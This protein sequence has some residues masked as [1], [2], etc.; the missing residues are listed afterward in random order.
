MHRAGDALHA[1]TTTWI[2]RVSCVTNG[3]A[4]NWVAGW[5]WG[6]LTGG[7]IPIDARALFPRE[8]EELLGLLRSLEEGDWGRP[9]VCPGWDVHDVTAHVLNDYVRRISGG[10]DGYGGAGFEVGET[11]PV[12]LGRV[13]GEFVRGLRQCSPRLMIELLEH[14]GPELDRVWAATDLAGAA[15][16]DVSWAGSGTSPAW[17]DLARE[18]TEFW[19]HQQQ[20][21]DA[22]SRPGADDVSMVRPVLVTLLHA[23]PVALGD[24]ARPAGTAVRFDVTGPAGGR[25]A[26]VSD[27]AKWELVGADVEEPAATVR[28]DQDTLWRLASRGISVESARQRADSIG[29]PELIEAATML[30]AVVA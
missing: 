28:M 25:W 15:Y 29:D 22:V 26:A 11:L 30:L 3:R 7:V 5:G 13:N 4:G 23:L 10:R 16:L 20:I 8:R 6:I 2:V 19:M 18:Y 27:G 24:R 12:Y 17:L 14:L 21:R 1:G 9:T